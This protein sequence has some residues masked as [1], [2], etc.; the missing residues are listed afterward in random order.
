M[1]IKQHVDAM[2]AMRQGGATWEAI[3]KHFDAHLDTVRTT[4]LMIYPD[5]PRQVPPSGKR[6]PPKQG[7]FQRKDLDVHR[8]IAMRQAGMTF[9]AIG[10]EVGSCG[11]TVFKYLQAAGYKT[12]EPVKIKQG[13]PR[14]IRMTD[15]EF[16]AYRDNGGLKWFRCILSARSTT[17]AP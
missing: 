14:Y 10:R 6:Q 11:K 9:K 13:Q 8:L 3:A 1:T 16:Q 17:D 7:Q 15:E 5:A 12:P 4:V 2:Y